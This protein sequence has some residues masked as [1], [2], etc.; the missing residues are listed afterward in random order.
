MVAP[1]NDVMH[2]EA[3]LFGF[4][5]AVRVDSRKNRLTAAFGE[6]ACLLSHGMRNELRQNMLG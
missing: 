1:K 5:L 2:F 3:V 6:S 4:P